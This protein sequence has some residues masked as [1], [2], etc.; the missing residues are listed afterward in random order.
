MSRFC[1][2]AIA[3]AGLNTARRAGAAFLWCYSQPLSPPPSLPVPPRATAVRAVDGG[4]GGEA[5][6]PPGERRGLSTRRGHSVLW[7][8][9]HGGGRRGSPAA[10]LRSDLPAG[11]PRAWCQQVNWTCGGT[12]DLRQLRSCNADLGVIKGWRSAGK[13]TLQ[14]LIVVFCFDIF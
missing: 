4:G 2:V 14:T 5:L 13:T 11:G 12:I 6:C 7:P 10:H 8:V 9:L 3:T 1:T